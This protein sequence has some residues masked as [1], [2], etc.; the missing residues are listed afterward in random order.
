MIKIDLYSATTNKRIENILNYKFKSYLY[1]LH[2]KLLDCNFTR[3][4][5]ITALVS[6]DIDYQ[7]DGYNIVIKKKFNSYG[8]SI[9]SVQ[10][11]CILYKIENDNLKYKR[12]Q[13]FSVE[14]LSPT[15]ERKLKIE[16]LGLV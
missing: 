7:Y 4:G 9:D 8:E 5:M 3:A 1:T 2:K 16:K 14:I 11:F 10:V 12:L 15:R 6:D 13:S